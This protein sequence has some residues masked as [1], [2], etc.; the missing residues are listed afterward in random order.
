MI[1]ADASSLVKYVLHEESWRDVS[2]LIRKRRPLRSVD[3]VTKE[4]GN[5][6]WKHCCLHG[7]ISHRKALEL[8]GGFMKLIQT[9]VILIEP[10]EEYLDAALQIALNHRVTLYDSL[11]LAQAQKYG[12][13][14][15]SDVKQ[16]EIADQLGVKVYLV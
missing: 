1:V 6:V 12:E 9:G 8:Y 10:E 11:Y 15:T 5:A 2:L 13:L 16:A 14:L 4:I 3:H 7:V